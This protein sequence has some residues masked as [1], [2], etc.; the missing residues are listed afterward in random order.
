MG[1]IRIS[2]FPQPYPGNPTTKQG[3]WTDVEQAVTSDH[4][5]RF[6]S[7]RTQNLCA[8]H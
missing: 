6:H 8:G 2:S 3:V 4:G 5:Q 1:P 7:G